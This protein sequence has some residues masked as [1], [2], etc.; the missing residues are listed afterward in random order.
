MSLRK[1]L[2]SLLLFDMLVYLL[3]VLGH[4]LHGMADSD[5]GGLVTTILAALFGAVEWMVVA[6]LDGLVLL[7]VVRLEVVQFGDGLLGLNSLVLLLGVRVAHRLLWLGRLDTWSLLLVLGL[8][9]VQLAEVEKGDVHLMCWRHGPL[10]VVHHA[11][12]GF[13]LGLAIFMMVLEP[14]TLDGG[15][16]VVELSHLVHRLVLVLV[17]ATVVA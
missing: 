10:T 13:L 11:F 15:R 1:L 5:R 12:L 16:V 3:L 8:R 9:L 14:A 6:W 7:L 2:L 17:C 4:D